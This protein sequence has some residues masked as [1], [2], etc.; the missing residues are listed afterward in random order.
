[1]KIAQIS[2]AATGGA[3]RVASLTNQ[4]LVEQGFK[5]THLHLQ[6]DSL[7]RAPF[8]HPIHTLAAGIDRY[9]VQKRES[10]LSQVSALRAQLSAFEKILSDY[11]IVHVHW[12]VGMINTNS[13]A[14]LAHERNVRIVITLHDEFTYTGGCHSAGNCLGYQSSCQNCPA[15]R[16]LFRTAISESV[17]Q[18]ELVIQ[19]I[20]DLGVIAPSGWIAKRALDSSTLRNKQITTIYNPVALPTFHL[21]PK[22]EKSRTTM[23]LGF[24]A[25]NIG[26]PNKGLNSALTMIRNSSSNVSMEVVGAGVSRD[27][28]QGRVKYLGPLDHFRMYE[29]ARAWDALLVCSRHENLPNTVLEMYLLGIPVISSNVGGIPNFLEEY[30]G[31][32]T[33]DSCSN[34]VRH[35]ELED[36]TKQAREKVNASMQDGATAQRFIDWN[37][38]YLE[39]VLGVYAA[40]A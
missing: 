30:G 9:L 28:V 10:R 8:R 33:F 35:P 22:P 18:K 27:D 32:V 23:T 36:L 38:A 40:D 5:G 24:V 2:F 34:D 7:W 11:D 39:K 14:R 17:Q 15:V 6:E 20:R 21:T 26:D 31:G 13:L 4:L 19:S 1:M 25:A 29:R 3:G 16:S 12:P 37:K